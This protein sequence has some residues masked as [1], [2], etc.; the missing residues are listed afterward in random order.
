M[1]RCL[2]R[3]LRC[4]PFLPPPACRCASLATIHAHQPQRAHAPCSQYHRIFGS[5]LC[6]DRSRSCSYVLSDR[7]RPVQAE[8]ELATVPCCIAVTARHEWAVADNVAICEADLMRRYSARGPH[9]QISAHLQQRA[10]RLRVPLGHRPKKRRVTST[11][12][13]TC[14]R[15]ALTSSALAA[16]N[17]KSTPR[18]ADARSFLA[19]FHACASR[20]T[21]PASRARA[22]ELKRQCP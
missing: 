10:H 17:R 12:M 7:I 19:S 4:R 15:K 13:A 20:P 18:G 11:P 22:G 14:L 9:I 21:P 1:L 3:S 2:C 16:F 6:L 8:S 5:R